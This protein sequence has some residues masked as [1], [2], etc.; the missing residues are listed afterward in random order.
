MEEVTFFYRSLTDPNLVHVGGF[1]STI[2]LFDIRKLRTV[3]KESK[4]LGGGVWRM[5]GKVIDGEEYIAIATCSG[6]QFKILNT[7]CKQK[8]RK[9]GESSHSLT[10]TFYSFLLLDVG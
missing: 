6:N 9:E 4:D 1:D 5:T 7:N 2:K 10:F 3:V 8:M